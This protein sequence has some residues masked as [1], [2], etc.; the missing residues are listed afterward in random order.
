M[1]SFKEEPILR[2]PCHSV[3]CLRRILLSTEAAQEEILAPEPQPI[4][5]SQSPLRQHGPAV[6]LSS[7]WRQH[8]R[9]SITAGA[10]SLLVQH[11]PHRARQRV[12]SSSLRSLLEGLKPH[13]NPT[14]KETLGALSRSRG[15]QTRPRGLRSGGCCSIVARMRCS[16]VRRVR[17]DVVEKRFSW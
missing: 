17:S 4:F 6:S 11:Q 14:H 1:L 12:P 5:P 3:L 8:G 2:R 7:S 10:A 9:C 16:C 13:L 15:A